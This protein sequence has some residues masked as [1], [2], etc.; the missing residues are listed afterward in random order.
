MNYLLS[1]KRLTF[2]IQQRILLK[3][4][5][6]GFKRQSFQNKKITNKKSYILYF[7]KLSFQLQQNILLKDGIFENKIQFLCV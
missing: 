4:G 3:R 5:T 7:E 1:S 6:L 2:Q